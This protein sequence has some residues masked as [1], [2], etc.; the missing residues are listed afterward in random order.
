MLNE[1]TFFEYLFVC[2]NSSH[3]Q[4]KNLKNILVTNTV[5][6][7]QP[8]ERTYIPHDPYQLD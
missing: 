7:T 4:K 3:P 8:D 2:E 5:A 1:F 6:T